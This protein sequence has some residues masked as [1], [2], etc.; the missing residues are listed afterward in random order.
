[1]LGL[2]LA[3]AVRPGWL[4]RE[5]RLAMTRV[6]VGWWGVAAWDGVR[7]WLDAV[8]RPTLGAVLG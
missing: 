6:P 2:V 4:V 1:M 5:R 7:V 3:G 8:Y